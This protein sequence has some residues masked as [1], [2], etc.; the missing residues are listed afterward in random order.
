M[1]KIICVTLLA[2]LSIAT[3]NAAE[4]S[5]LGQGGY[6]GLE[7]GYAKL[8]NSNNGVGLGRLFAG[9][10]FNENLGLELGGYRTSNTD[11]YYP[12]ATFRVYAYGTDASLMLRPSISSGLHGLF[13]RAGGH[14]DQINA[15]CYGYPP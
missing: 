4:N 10:N 15:D 13:I 5:N 2:V 8:E 14:Y 9:Y 6:L 3:L 12:G 7:A 11:Y 1:K